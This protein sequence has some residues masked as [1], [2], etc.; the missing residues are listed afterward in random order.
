MIGAQEARH[1]SEL[2]RLSHAA[3]R[4]ARADVAMNS[5]N[6]TLVPCALAAG[7][8]WSDT[9]WPTSRRS[10]AMS[11][12]APSP[13]R[14]FVNAMPAAR[15]TAVGAPPARGALAPMFSTLMIRPQLRCFIPGQASR[16]SRIAA[17][18]FSS[19][20]S[21]QISSVI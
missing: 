6:G 20:S 17:N 4:D 7:D 8:H 13:A 11:C 3:E 14:T 18:S 21:C 5:S 10:P 2:F 16:A 15:D 12:G 9:I 1:G 19:R